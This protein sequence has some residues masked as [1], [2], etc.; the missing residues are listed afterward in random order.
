MTLSG[1]EPATFQLVTQCNHLPQDYYAD[2]YIYIMPLV[3]NI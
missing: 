3:Q 2:I 1:I